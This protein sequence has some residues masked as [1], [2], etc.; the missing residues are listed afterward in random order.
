[1]LNRLT[2][3]VAV[4]EG[5]LLLFCTKVYRLQESHRSEFR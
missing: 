1:M 4:I 5:I 3:D 2:S